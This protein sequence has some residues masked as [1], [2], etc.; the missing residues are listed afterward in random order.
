MPKRSENFRAGD[1]RESITLAFLQFLGFVAPVPRTEDVGLDGVLTLAQLKNGMNFPMRT[2]GVQIKS[3]SLQCLEYS[4][5]RMRWYYGLPFP[6]FIVARGDGKIRFYSTSRIWML[7]T[8][9]VPGQRE[10]DTSTLIRDTLLY[11]G[12]YTVEAIG[13]VHRFPTEDLSEILGKSVAERHK[14]CTMLG[15]PIV[16]FSESEI[17]SD[18]DLRA[19]IVDVLCAHADAEKRVKLLRTLGQMPTIEWETNDAPR[20]AKG[21]SYGGAPL[22]EDQNDIL[23]HS[24]KFLKGV[25]QNRSDLKVEDAI[26]TLEAGLS[27]IVAEMPTDL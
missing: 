8:G 19:R 14:F 1:R 6:L 23:R 7:T 18:I 27:D 13:D 2:I 11:F 3:P 5:E 24:L 17:E 21:W 9:Q 16:E 15:E 10:L 12:R 26:A 22:T 25:I 4:A 20:I